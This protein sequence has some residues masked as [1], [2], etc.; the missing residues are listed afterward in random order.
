MRS[1]VFEEDEEERID[2]YEV[3]VFIDENMYT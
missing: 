3:K 1:T 2:I